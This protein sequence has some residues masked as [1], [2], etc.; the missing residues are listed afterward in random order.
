VDELGRVFGYMGK[1]RKA[2]KILLRNLNERHYL[3]WHSTNGKKIL[4]MD[5][6]V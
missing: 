4:S 1:V 3:G 5:S 6:C 2:Y